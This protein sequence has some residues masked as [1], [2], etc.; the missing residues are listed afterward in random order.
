VR[1]GLRWALLA[2]L[3][4]TAATWWWGS[5]DAKRLPAVVE[6]VVRPA[7]IVPAIAYQAPLPNELPQWSVPAA[8]RDI[9]MAAQPPEPP[10]PAPVAEPVRTIEPEAP[11]APALNYRYFG[12]MQSP[13]GDVQTLL[14]REGAPA[15]ITVQEGTRLEEGY[16]VQKVDEQAIRLTYPPLGTVVDIPI[17]PP[18]GMDSGWT[19]Q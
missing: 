4:A 16:V 7:A 8:V 1:A 9:F 3:L 12:R 11:V 15:P 14:Q 18:P 19:K 17:P 13:A 10:K 5:G 2:T 6:A